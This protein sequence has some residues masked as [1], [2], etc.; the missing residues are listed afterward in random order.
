MEDG[1]ILEL[2]RQRDE[3]A[4]AETRA[5][6]G[7]RLRRLAANILR[8]AEDAEE[9]ESDVYLRAWEAIPPARPVHFSAWLMKLCRNEALRR[10]ER[11]GAEKRRADLTEWTAELEA[12][13]PDAAAERA[14]EARE[15]GELLSAF[16]RTLPEESRAVFVRRYFLCE[17]VKEVAA[18]LGLSESKVKSS[19]F[20]ARNRLRDYL[21]KEGIAL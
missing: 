15:L 1:A 17:S 2:F 19:L 3:A 14:F 6:Y 7:P 16:L 5:K 21:E 12:C 13:I 18:A 10:L 8:S 20:R 11:A 4:L 9:C